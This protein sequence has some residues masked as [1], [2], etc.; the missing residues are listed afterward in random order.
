MSSHSQAFLLKYF[1][2]ITMTLSGNLTTTRKRAY[3][4][5]FSKIF[6]SLVVWTGL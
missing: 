1:Q 3:V 2:Q 4:P 5:T 6:A